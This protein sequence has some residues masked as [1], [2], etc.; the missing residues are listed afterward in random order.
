MFFVCILDVSPAMQQPTTLGLSL[1][2]CA[3]SAVEQLLTSRRQEGAGARDQY[4]LL[5]ASSTPFTPSPLSCPA[6]RRPH[7]P[8]SLNTPT[9]CAAGTTRTRSSPPRSN[10]SN[11][12]P[13]PPPPP[14]TP[15]PHPPNPLSP[16]PTSPPPSPPPSTCSTSTRGPT[17]STTSARGASPGTTSRPSSSSSPPTSPPPPPPASSS[18]PPPLSASTAPAFEWPASTTL[19]SQ[20]ASAP[21]RWDQR[22]FPCI[23]RLPLRPLPLPPPHPRTSYQSASASGLGVGGGGGGGERGGGGGGAGRVSSSPHQ[24]PSPLSQYLQVPA[25]QTGGRMFIAPSLRLLLSHIDGLATRTPPSLL[26]HLHPQAGDLALTP[27]TPTPLTPPPTP[28]STPTP[29]PCP[30]AD[31]V[32]VYVQR[33]GHVAHSGDLRIDRCHDLAPPALTSPHAV[34]LPARAPPPLPTDRRPLPFSLPLPLPLVLPSLPRLPPLESSLPYD[35]LPARPPP[36]PHPPPH[37]RPPPHL[38]LGVD[39]R[40]R[41]PP[42]RSGHRMDRGK[43]WGRWRGRG[44]QG[45]EDDAG[46]AALRL[47]HPP[48]PPVPHRR[49]PPLAPPSPPPPPPPFT[50]PPPCTA[51]W[52]PFSLA[53]PRTPQRPCTPG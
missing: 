46:A 34:L 12:L 39:E 41:H 37:L 6:S 22:I 36:A 33:G 40:R 11:L 9:C 53:V 25:E 23:L 3:K 14:L 21:Y 29:T 13:P 35:T 18:P 28:T 10:P 1:L 30:T 5:V 42:V 7:P 8:S 52:P 26:L 38:P 51:S 32:G 16:S 17:A 50:P 20:L 45:R 4:H 27:P 49:A 15:T 19:G 44:E 31:Y 48:V 2:E 47:P 24:P 43:G